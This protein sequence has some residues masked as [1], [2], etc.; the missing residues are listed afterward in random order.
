LEGVEE[1]AV[2]EE[3]WRYVGDVGAVSGGL[4]LGLGLAEHEDRNGAVHICSTALWMMGWTMRCVSE[5]SMFFCKWSCDSSSLT[6][7][8][9]VTIPRDDT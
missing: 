7:F 2:V 1:G 8:L 6:N 5:I 4:G 3:L 9:F